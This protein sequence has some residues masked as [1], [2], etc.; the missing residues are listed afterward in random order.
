MSSNNFEQIIQAPT[1]TAMIVNNLNSRTD[2]REHINPVLTLNEGTEYQYRFVKEVKGQRIKLSDSETYNENHDIPYQFIIGTLKYFIHN[3]DAQR[4]ERERGWHDQTVLLAESKKRGFSI[5]VLV[6]M[7]DFLVTV[8]SAER[9]LLSEYES[10][11]LSSHPLERKL[12]L[13][14]LDLDAYLEKTKEKKKEKRQRIARKYPSFWEDE[15]SGQTYRLSCTKHLK[16]ERSNTSGERLTLP[17]DAVRDILRYAMDH[18]VSALKKYIGSSTKEKKIVLIFPSPDKSYNVGILIAIDDLLVTIISMYDVPPS[19]KGLST[20]IFP[21]A[22]R[23]VLA[24]YN[25]EEFMEEYDAKEAERI[26][27]RKQMLERQLEIARKQGD[28]IRSFSSLDEYYDRKEVKIIAPTRKTLIG[29]KKI[30]K[31]E[32]VKSV[33][34]EVNRDIGSKEKLRQA[35]LMGLSVQM[36]KVKIDKSEKSRG[37]TRPKKKRSK[38]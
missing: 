14:D 1:L 28:G 9:V 38:K 22:K 12:F 13:K 19:D 29:L 15:S 35:A 34:Q 10:K 20:L 27:L 25:L 6:V 11:T 17:M 5:A 30:T 31:V 21:D 32:E 16:E 7:R 2:D 36:L 8:I 33:E 26:V 18:S 3:I 23:I 4:T 37:K 24:D